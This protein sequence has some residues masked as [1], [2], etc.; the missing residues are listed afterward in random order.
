[1]RLDVVEN[2]SKRLHLT[3][4]TNA[5][6][7]AIFGAMFVLMGLWCTRLLAVEASIV[8]EQQRFAYTQTCL[9]ILDCGA[10]HSAVADVRD[11]SLV[12]HEIEV[13]LADG[14][15]RLALPQ[16]DGD[17]KVAIARDIEA[18]LARPGTSF[19]HVEGS[20]LAGL[21]LGLVCIGGGLVILSAIQ[22]VGLTADRTAG[23]LKVTRRLLLW[24]REKHLQIDL[25]V[26]DTVR[27]IP[28][29]L[30]TGKHIVTSYSVALQARG[31]GIENSLRVTFLPM[32][33]EG[34]ANELSRIIRAWIRVG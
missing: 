14:P 4:T 16:S 26:L 27:V 1:M 12:D 9:W 32:F 20:P 2:D 28:S 31:Q 17:E 33:T 5:P 15:H 21:L 8:V 34:D 24:P 10:V 18:A 25:A 29:T 3:L 23:T 30:R 11:V 6:L 19:R 22:W 7:Y 13:Q